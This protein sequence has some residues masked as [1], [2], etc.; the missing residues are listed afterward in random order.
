MRLIG[1]LSHESNARRFSDYLYVQGIDNKVEPA[2]GGMWNIWVHDER[3]IEQAKLVLEEFHNNPDAEKFRKA[4]GTARQKK[5][6]EQEEYKAYQKRFVTADKIFPGGISQMGRLTGIL[7]VISVI[8]SLVSRLGADRN[9]LNYL[10]ITQ[11]RVAGQY[12]QWYKGLP[13]I[14]HGQ[15][16]R[17]FTPMFIHFGIIHL[18]FNMLWLRNLGTM[19]EKRQNTWIFALLVLVIAAASNLGQYLVSGPSFGGMS[20]VVYGLLGYIWIRGKFDPFSGLYLHQQT[21]IMMIFWFFLCLSGV[22]GN[23]ANTAHGV[24]LVIGIVWGFVSAR[25]A[26][27]KY[28]R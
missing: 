4:T 16:W 18:L 6:Q 8:V 1:Q 13:E 24:G 22:I 17:L 27:R 10:F 7:I 3:Q 11:T 19:I 20:G 15:I 9:L 25:L 12:L 26:K 23:V 28:I 14:M 21:V 5:K 2:D